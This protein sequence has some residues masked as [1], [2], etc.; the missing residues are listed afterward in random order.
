MREL[1]QIVERRDQDKLRLLSEKL[2]REEDEVAISGNAQAPGADALS[3][4]RRMADPIETPSKCQTHSRE[5]PPPPPPQSTA[6]RQW[7]H[8]DRCYIT[9][10]RSVEK[11][12]RLV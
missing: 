3:P 11:L 4:A 12:T 7:H 10:R 5:P 9:S 8:I 6:R 1:R 2:R